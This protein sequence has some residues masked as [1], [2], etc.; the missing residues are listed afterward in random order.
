MVEDG[1]S[2]LHCSTAIDLA[3]MQ[4]AGVAVAR[5]HDRNIVSPYLAP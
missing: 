4:V 5:D 1:K 3:E 2:R